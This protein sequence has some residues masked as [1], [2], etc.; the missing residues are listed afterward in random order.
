MS[1]YTLK[2]F[3]GDEEI[4]RFDQRQASALY[5]ILEHPRHHRVGE[6]GPWG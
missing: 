6:V 2:T 3:Y 5:R 4:E 1:R